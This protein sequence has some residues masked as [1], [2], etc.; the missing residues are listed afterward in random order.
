M[1]QPGGPQQTRGSSGSKLRTVLLT[2]A[3]SRRRRGWAPSDAGS[4]EQP[5]A[6]ARVCPMPPCAR[7]VT[8]RGPGAGSDPEAHGSAGYTLRG[9]KPT[10]GSPCPAGALSQ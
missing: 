4:W 5:G 10:W 7:R 6:P 2:A 8:M 9:P 3:W 1:E